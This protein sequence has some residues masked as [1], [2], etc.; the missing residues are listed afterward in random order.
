MSFT[1]II[2]LFAFFPISILGYFLARFFEKK[3]K[4]S[5]EWLGNVVLVLL[6]LGFY[7]WSR[8]DG[9]FYF[10]FYMI[11]IYLLGYLVSVSAQ[12][13]RKARGV[14][15]VSLVLVTAVLFYY[16]YYNFVVTSVPGVWRLGFETR[17]IIVP[18]GISF[19]T[20]SAISY[21]MDV[22]RGQAPR[23]NLLDVLLYL[24]FFPKVISGPIVLWKDFQPQVGKRAIDDAQFLYGLNRMMVGFAKKVILA[25]TFGLLVNDIQGQ[26]SVR[27]IDGPTSWICAF[28]YMLQ[29]YYDFSGYSDIAIGISAMFGFRFKENFNFPYTSLSITEFWRRWHISLGTWF[30]EYLYI[31][32]GGNRKGKGRTLVNLGIVFL[33]TGI[34]HGAGW[35]Y[36]WWGAL[37]GFFMIIERLSKDKTLYK[38]VPNAIKWIA[39]MVIVFFSWQLFRFP[40]MEDFTTFMKVMFGSLVFT[41]INFTWAYFLSRK[42]VIYMIVAVLGA[43]LLRM[44]W[45]QRIKQRLNATKAGLA[46]Q[47]TVLLLLMVFAV[48]C[49]VNSSYSPFIYFQY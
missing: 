33:T 7:A 10:L 13:S 11:L 39:T 30:R 27:G 8:L 45:F 1:N 3:V 23:G 18:A 47:E 4:C 22:Y 9:V 42:I 25:D 43:T 40:L 34:W 38:K 19:I 29:I 21:L 31:P 2:F 6:S 24:S 41:D 14:L 16:K 5:T 35:N 32:L 44:E 28:A 15:A 49:M 20:F 46:V 26:L 36:I 48:I 12:K 37:N 17:D